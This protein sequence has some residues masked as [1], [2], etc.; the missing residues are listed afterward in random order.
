MAYGMYVN[1]NMGNINSNTDDNN[2][3]INIQTEDNF[4]IVPDGTYIWDEDT[5]Y[6]KT[7]DT[8]PDGYLQNRANIYKTNQM[9]YKTKLDEI[10]PEVF[11]WND[12]MRDPMTNQ[13]IIILTN[14]L[15]DYKSC[16]EAWVD[17]LAAKPPRID[18]QDSVKILKTS[19]IL[20]NSNFADAYRSSVRGALF[21]YGNKVLRVDKL[22]G[23]NVKAV[24]IPVKCWIPFVNKNDITTI[25]VNVIFNIFKDSNNKYFC[26]FVCYYEDGRIKKYTFEYNFG[27][28]ALGELIEETDYEEAFN[29]AGISPIVVFTGYN[30]DGEVY[31]CELYS[32]WDA[33]IASCMRAYQAMMQMIERAKEITRVFPDGATKTDDDMGITYINQTGVMAYKDI[34]HPP[35]VDYKIPVVNME[36]VIAAYNEALERLSRDTCLSTTFFNTAELKSNTSGETLKASMYR[37]E[38]HSKSLCTLLLRSL[39]QLICKMALAADIELHMDEF[40]VI[41][42][43]GFVQDLKQQMEILQARLGSANNIKTMSEADA[44]A[45]YDDVPMSVAV[46]RA[47]ELKGKVINENEDNTGN[48]DSGNESTVTNGIGLTPGVSGTNKTGVVNNDTNTAFPVGPDSI[49]E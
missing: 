40:D 31:G 46:K 5:F 2:G 41:Q 35:Q 14:R 21:M 6:F 28:K 34:E 11:A 4:G 27:A 13:Q 17:L 1:P 3:N 8:F 26:E 44:I 19:N 47:Q 29:G 39:K 16:T 48:T 12:M 7:G 37:T 23:G 22:N 45:E 36:P 42:F 20:S 30:I 25:E 10:Y 43:N 9:L 33:A 38:L 18:G 32:D 15:A 24:E 49:G